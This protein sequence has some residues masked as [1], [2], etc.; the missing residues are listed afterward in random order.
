MPEDII[1]SSNFLV[2]RNNFYGASISVR[3]TLYANF[4]QIGQPRYSNSAEVFNPPTI[5]ELNEIFIIRTIWITI[6]MSI[7][8]SV[9]RNNLEF[10]IT[11]LCFDGKLHYQCLHLTCTPDIA[12]VIRIA[13]IFFN[14]CILPGGYVTPGKP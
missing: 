8:Q 3:G 13:I 5:E 12:D 10:R 11:R 14:Y 2:I 1:F 4:T 6:Y 7:F 9:L